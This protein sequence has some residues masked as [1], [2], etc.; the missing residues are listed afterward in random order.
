MD[1]HI[2]TADVFIAETGSLADP[3]AAAVHEND[4]DTSLQV[5]D[6][7][8]ERSDFIA[9]RDKGDIL[10]EPSKRKLIRI[11]GLVKDVDREEAKLRNDGIDG[12]VR[13]VTLP[14]DPV[15]EL[16]L[17]LPG[18]LRGAFAEMLRHV[19]EVSR[20]IGRVG[21]DG[22]FRQTAESDHILIT[23]EI[24]HKGFLLKNIVIATNETDHNVREESRS[25][26]EYC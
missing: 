1:L 5:I 2:G 18:N 12:A 26:K 7:I 16:P 15:N 9:G 10:I 23:L 4:D 8:D 17:L 6:S 20:D 22:I 24:I 19:V 3:K 13:E 11:P 25:K 14:L 21:F